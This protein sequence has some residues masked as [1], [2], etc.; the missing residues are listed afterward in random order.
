VFGS[1]SKEVTLL[2]HEVEDITEAVQL[3]R[4]VAEQAQIAAEQSKALA[5]MQQ[6]L[7]WRK[8]QLDSADKALAQHVRRTPARESLAA[9]RARFDLPNMSRYFTSDDL[10]PETGIYTAYHQPSCASS[11]LRTFLE[12]GRAFPRCRLCAEG[13]FYR[14]TVRTSPSL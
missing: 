6:D 12:Q 10:V 5:Q 8:A 2:I 14:F 13:V 9:L 11:P 7:R 4:W 3:R 1:G